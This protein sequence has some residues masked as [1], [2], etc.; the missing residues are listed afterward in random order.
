MDASI[1]RPDRPVTEYCRL[2]GHSTCSSRECGCRLGDHVIYHEHGD[3]AAPGWRGPTRNL[4]L[5]R[6]QR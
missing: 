1:E 4:R 2:G 6:G 5:V 3:Q